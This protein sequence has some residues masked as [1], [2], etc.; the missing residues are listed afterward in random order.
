MSSKEGAGINAD[1]EV[2]DA[3]QRLSHLMALP[4]HSTDVS[5]VTSLA[6]GMSTCSNYFVFV[7]NDRTL[8][9]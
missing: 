3:M 5:L 6:C 7:N 1:T 2:V 9:Q 4:P 8:V